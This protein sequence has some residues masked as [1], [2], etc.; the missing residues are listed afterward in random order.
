MRPSRRTSSPAPL[1]AALLFPHNWKRKKSVAWDRLRDRTLGLVVRSVAKDLVVKDCLGKSWR[2]KTKILKRWGESF[3]RSRLALVTR[4]RTRYCS[5]FRIRFAADT[6]CLGRK[7]GGKKLLC[8]R[9]AA[10]WGQPK[11]HLLKFLDRPE[12]QVAHGC[13]KPKTSAAR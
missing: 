10:E 6:L 8:V 3:T 1:I 12:R 7:G 13:C 4:H 2:G 9:C 11:F 5:D